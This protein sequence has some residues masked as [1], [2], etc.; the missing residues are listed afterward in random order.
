M[1][2]YGDETGHINDYSY[3]NENGKSYDNRWMHRP[4][5]DWDKI[6]DIDKEGTIEHRIFQATQKLITLRK[7]LTVV[8]DYSNITWLTPHNIHV[9]GYLRAWGDKKLF[10]LY[11]YS[12][13]TA[14]VTWYTFK[15]HGTSG[16]LYDHWH[17]KELTVGKDE[18]YLIIEPYGFCLLEAK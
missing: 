7:K 14:Y 17:E 9:A 2:F 16:K 5:I 18:E 8:S 11:N 3:L 6:D 13:K 15:E 10:C 12:D 4:V 1:L